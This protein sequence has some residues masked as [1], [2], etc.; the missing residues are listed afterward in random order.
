M[1]AEIHGKVDHGAAWEDTVPDAVFS[2]CGTHPRPPAGCRVA[3]RSWQLLRAGLP[4]RNP[5]DW[6][7]D[8]LMLLDRSI[9]ARHVANQD[10]FSTRR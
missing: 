2:R 9:S 7:M 5:C 4:D 10:R 1:R 3:S 6:R 8:A